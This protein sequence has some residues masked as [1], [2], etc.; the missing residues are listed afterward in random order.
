MTQ[1]GRQLVLAL[2][3]LVF[4]FVMTWAILWITDKTV[5]L[6]VSDADQGAGLDM[7]DHAEAGYD[8]L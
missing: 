5:G 8:R 6:R 1:F 3:G 4:P 2:A 7:S